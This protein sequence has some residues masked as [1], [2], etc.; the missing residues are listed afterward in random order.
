MWILE[1]IL[2][3]IQVLVV[4]SLMAFLKKNPWETRGFKS[5]ICVLLTLVSL[6][7]SHREKRNNNIYDDEIDSWYKSI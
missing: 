2:L 3:A 5:F 6:L 4:S 1:E 7:I